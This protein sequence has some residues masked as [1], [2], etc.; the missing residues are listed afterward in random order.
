M[1]EAPYRYSEAPRCARCAQR[2]VLT[3]EMAERLAVASG[4]RLAVFA[5]LD[6]NGWHVWN[7]EVELQPAAEPLDPLGP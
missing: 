3:A 2:A 1:S 6:G 5:C 7:P 4:G